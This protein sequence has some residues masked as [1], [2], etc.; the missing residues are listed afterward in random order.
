MP[1]NRVGWRRVAQ[2]DFPK[3]PALE[4]H[5][6]VRT[7]DCTAD[8]GRGGA[9]SGGE[10]EASATKVVAGLHDTMVLEM[11]LCLRGESS[12]LCIVF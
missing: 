7:A 9:V 12:A 3:P 2:A 8:T 10:A 5:Q 4:A 6:G 11:E 1:V